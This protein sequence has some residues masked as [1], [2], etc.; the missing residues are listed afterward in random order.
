MQDNY[1]VKLCKI[2]GFKPKIPYCSLVIQQNSCCKKDNI[3][4]HI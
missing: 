1:L 3:I 2:D 4:I